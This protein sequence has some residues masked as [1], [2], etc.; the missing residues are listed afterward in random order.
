M[1]LRLVALLVFA[2]L[3]FV[4]HAGAQTLPAARRDSIL[5]AVRGFIDVSNRADIQG[6]IDAYSASP[7][8]SSVAIGALRRGPAAIRAAADSAAGMEGVMRVSLGAIDVTPLGSANTLAVA[9]VVI[10]VETEQG[11]VQ[12]RGAYTVVLERSAGA[13][14]IL[15]DHLSLPLSED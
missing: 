6:I 2:L 9:S 7:S 12:L 4:E 13:W 15:H 8:V 3:G 14:K 10:R 5:T 1:K 11:P